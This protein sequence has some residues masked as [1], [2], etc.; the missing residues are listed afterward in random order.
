MKCVWRFMCCAAVLCGVLSRAASAGEA[1][2]VFNSL[3]GKDYRQVLSTRDRADDIALAKQ[4]VEAAKTAAGQPN[5]LALLCE[6]ACLL[7]GRHPGGHETAIKAMTLLAEKVPAKKKD[8][9]E[10]LLTLY[11]ARY[12]ASPADGRAA[13]GEDLINYFM[14]LA[15]ECGAEGDYTA[16]VLYLRR[17]SYTARSV[18]SSSGEVIVEKLK[19]FIAQERTARDIGQAKARLKADPDDT[20]ARP[21]LAWLYLVEKDDPAEAAK[22]LS[23]TC[24]EAMKTYVPLLVKDA[25]SL[26]DTACLE[27]ADWYRS[28]SPRASAFASPAMLCR[29]KGYY[30]V[31]LARPTAKGMSRTKAELALKKVEEALAEYQ[32]SLAPKQATG[33]SVVRLPS[34]TGKGG[35]PFGEMALVSQ[36]GSVTGGRPWTIETSHPR[37]RLRAVAFSRDG[38]HVAMA[39][40]SGVIRICDAATGK[41]ARTLMGHEGC[42]NA[43]A[44]SPGGGVLASASSD[45]TVRL[46]NART[47]RCVGALTGHK[48]AVT[49]VSWSPDA[50][51][52]ATG[53]WDRRVALWDARSG[54]ATL[55]LPE[56]GHEV[57]AVAWAPNGKW[58]AT[59]GDY[60]D[61][62]VAVWDARG[63]C[64]DVIKGGSAICAFAWSPDSRHLA[65]GG[66][67]RHDVA[68]FIWHSALRKV[69]KELKDNV[70]ATSAL[71]WSPDGK[72]LASEG[73]NGTIV[74]WDVGSWKMAFALAFMEKSGGEEGPADLAWSPDSKCIVAC[75]NEH[76]NHGV[77]KAGLWNTETGRNVWLIDARIPRFTAMDYSS[78][79]GR[80]AYCS[81][82]RSGRPTL[83]LCDARSGKVQNH[84]EAQEGEA[85]V[86]AWSPDGRT[87]AAGAK[88]TLQLW[89]PNTGVLQ[90]KIKSRRGS[91]AG[92][93]WSPDGKKVAACGENTSP[94]IIDPASGAVMKDLTDKEGSAHDLVWSPDGRWLAVP[95]SHGGDRIYVWDVHTDRVPDVL[96]GPY[97]GVLA[98]AWSPD[99]K[100][101]ATGLGDGTVRIWGVAPCRPIG[102][103]SGHESAVYAVAWSPDGKTIASGERADKQRTPKIC[104]WDARGG[105]LLATLGGHTRNIVDLTWS[106]DSKAFAS[107]CQKVIRLWDAKSRRAILTLL[108]VLDAGHIAVNYNGHFRMPEGLDAEKEIVYLSADGPD[109]LAPSEF[110]EKYGWKNDPDKVGR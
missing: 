74:G 50:G 91:I 87:L 36:P 95:T 46:W 110:A 9:R 3:Y 103:F 89:D 81:Y 96:P 19:R 67:H 10:K 75:G 64:R 92:V 58:L 106:A 18:R 39:G 105:E 70:T 45:G 15:D 31:F 6:R 104:L 22:Y 77:V 12:G 84:W 78:G 41:L 62:Q 72:K 24:E 17:A 57:R 2:Q 76:P 108:P 8:C 48:K 93:A 102:T 79:A 94:Q 83:W 14:V 42:I 26:A 35:G 97:G 61:G 43:L 37:G 68:V 20:T 40:R 88:D 99:S 1:E 13:A 32:A 49:C 53:S 107:A 38:K 4:L 23:A 28:L 52:L 60:G 71:A 34:L 11:Q 100:M 73:M 90:H 101:L 69:V 109:V 59:A 63:A 27:L 30:G 85:E 55:L 47:G 54:K 65:F 29:A 98:A 44:Y 33:T 16:A 25:N 66:Q 56:H 5:L 51:T 82:Q 86:L 80:L 7:A 21:R